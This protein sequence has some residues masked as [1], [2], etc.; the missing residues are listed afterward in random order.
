MAK[1]DS[2]AAAAVAAATTTCLLLQW[3]CDHYRLQ[4]SHGNL[5]KSKINTENENE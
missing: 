3:P 2:L 1:A 4:I 5:G